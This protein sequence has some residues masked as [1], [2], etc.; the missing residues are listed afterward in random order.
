MALIAKRLRFEAALRIG[1]APALY[2][3]V[4]RL[5]SRARDQ[6]VGQNTQLVIE[7]F[8]R[9][10]NTFAVVAFRHAQTEPVSIAH[11]LHVPAQVIRAVKFMIPTIVLIRDPRDAVLSLMMREPHFS[12]AKLLQYY[13]VYYEMVFSYR[14]SFVLAPFEQVTTDFGEIIRRTNV[15]FGT[16]FALFRHTDENLADVFRTVEI[17]DLADHGGKKV[18]PLT[19]ARPSEDRDRMRVNVQ[20]NLEKA[21]ASDNARRALEAFTSLLLANNKV[22]SDGF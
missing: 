17:M 1:Q 3:P 8:P 22:L 7:G 11:H 19:V 16:N 14:H 9:S 13:A 5:Y 15:Q 20:G 10:A 4:A 6:L 21:L 18:N 2:F 12:P